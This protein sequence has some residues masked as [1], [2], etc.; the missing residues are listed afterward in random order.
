[1]GQQGDKEKMSELGRTDQ[2]PASIRTSSA[3]GGSEA[4]RFPF[5]RNR[6]LVRADKMLAYVGNDNLPV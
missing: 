4:L 5:P 6:R 3:S 1:M 2:K